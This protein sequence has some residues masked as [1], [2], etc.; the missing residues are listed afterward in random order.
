MATGSPERHR[1]NPT[2]IWMFQAENIFLPPH[3]HIRLRRWEAERVVRGWSLDAVDC[4]LSAKW[5]TAILQYLLNLFAA[6]F[7]AF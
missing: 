3:I 4:T 5:V 6:D 1:A 7:V 2:Q